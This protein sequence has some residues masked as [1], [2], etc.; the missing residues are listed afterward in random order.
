M[1]ITQRIGGQP[2]LRKTLTRSKPHIAGTRAGKRELTPA[3][4]S[5]TS[6]SMLG[7]VPATIC[8]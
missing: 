7:T 8:V 2:G 3:R 4:S 5:L 6:T 1:L